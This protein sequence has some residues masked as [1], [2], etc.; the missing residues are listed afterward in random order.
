MPI[1]Y[2]LSL[3]DR[4]C[5]QNNGVR[6]NITPC[7]FPMVALPQNGASPLALLPRASPLNATSPYQFSIRLSHL[8]SFRA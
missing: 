5:Y 6:A 3:I 1:F 8:A 7:F 4:P 2:H